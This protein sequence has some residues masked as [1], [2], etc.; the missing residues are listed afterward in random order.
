[1]TDFWKVSIFPGMWS[2][3]RKTAE[4]DSVTDSMDMNLNKLQETVEDWETRHTAV[5]GG[6][7]SQTQLSDWTTTQKTA[8]Q[9]QTMQSTCIYS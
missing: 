3:L 8:L 9:A 6:A 2:L 1:M 4:D 7:K 5:H